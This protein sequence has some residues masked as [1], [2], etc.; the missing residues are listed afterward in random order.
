FSG[1]TQTTVR[2]CNNCRIKIYSQCFCTSAYTTQCEADS[3]CGSVRYSIGSESIFTTT[4][5]V[6]TSDCNRTAQL[7]GV[8][9]LFTYNATCCNSDNCNGGFAVQAPHIT[10]LTLLAI[11]VVYVILLGPQ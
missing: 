11:F 9:K 3:S 8:M 2:T 10:I 5:C 4:G 1:H 6:T 7:T